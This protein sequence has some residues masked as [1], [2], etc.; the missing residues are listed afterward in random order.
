MNERDQR[1]EAVERGRIQ[2]IRP[3]GGANPQDPPAPDRLAYELPQAGKQPLAG[4]GVAR[5]AG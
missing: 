3:V 2:Q 1:R 5:L 4:A